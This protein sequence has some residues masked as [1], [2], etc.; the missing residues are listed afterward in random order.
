MYVFQ[1]SGCF[2]KCYQVA[3]VKML[4]GKEVPGVHNERISVYTKTQ[5]KS[6]GSVRRI[7]VGE[8]I[9]FVIIITAC[10][11]TFHFSGHVELILVSV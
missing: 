10:T 7:C 6:K 5:D 4:L 11:I 1:N 3:A 8:K 9:H 2:V